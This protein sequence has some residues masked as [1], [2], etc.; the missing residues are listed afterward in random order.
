[1]LI[2]E[3][4]MGRQSELWEALTFWDVGLIKA[5]SLSNGQKEIYGKA[6]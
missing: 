1:M 6:K 2:E 3:L 5:F 4:S